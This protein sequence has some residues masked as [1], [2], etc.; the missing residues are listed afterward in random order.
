MLPI[1][2]R[3]KGL[4]G[5]RA[6]CFSL[7]VDLCLDGLACRWSLRCGDMAFTI[8]LFLID[9]H[10]CYCHCCLVT[11]VQGLHFSL[12]ASPC[13]ELSW[14]Q[15]G[16]QT[17]VADSAGEVNESWFRL[18]SAS[19][20]HGRVGPVGSVDEW[21]LTYANDVQWLPLLP[22]FGLENKLA[23]E[24]P[25]DA[26]SQQHKPPTNKSA[27]TSQRRLVVPL[28]CPQVFKSLSGNFFGVL[29]ISSKTCCCSSSS[30]CCRCRRRLSLTH[31]DVCCLSL[32]VMSSAVKI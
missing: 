2:L 5:L 24:R 31:V 11:C 30:C 9:C 3:P 13:I 20:I 14:W 23:G 27:A 26:T 28:K 16:W 29:T 18:A 6:M 21:R 7:A 10:C 15:R 25:R 17:S 8:R 19:A 1:H 32:P 12:P 22:A 4:A